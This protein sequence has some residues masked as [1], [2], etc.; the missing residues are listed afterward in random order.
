MKRLMVGA[1]L[2]CLL[3]SG[4]RWRDAGELS[5]VTAAA[6]ARDAGG[7]VL[8]AELTLPQADSAALSAQTVTGEGESAAQAID[9]AG[10][11][12]DA[13][14][15]WSHARV[16]LL[17]ESVLAGDMTELVRN[18]SAAAAVRP[19]VRL[20]AVKGMSADTVLAGDSGI[21]GDPAG[22]SL[23]DSAVQAVRQ[24]QTPDMPLFRVLDVVQTDGID[25]VLPAVQ[26][27]DGQAVLSGSALFSGGEQCGWLDEA[28]TSV[29]CVLLQ[30]GE[31]AVL[32]DG[33]LRMELTNLC[34]EVSAF[35]A[36]GTFAVSVSAS[37]ACTGSGQTQ[38]TASALR[39]QCAQVISTLQRT[40]CDALG[41]GR[42]WNRK[43]PASYQ[44]AGAQAWRTAP[45][46]VQVT[47]HA[48]QETEGGST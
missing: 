13:Q 44:A 9:R 27:Q 29:L 47:L 19:S 15:Y 33:D 6:V 37:L 26:L 18:L 48:T 1:V 14:L 2:L 30:S 10:V 31:Q 34:A 7:Y 24:S 20:F 45:V 25:P 40:G 39:K 46:T 22:F 43:N 28:Q 35:P 41:F 5:A 36:E 38:R 17:D 12:R 42:E 11:G 23:G 4:C 8:T 16:L 21:S 3:L 32:Y